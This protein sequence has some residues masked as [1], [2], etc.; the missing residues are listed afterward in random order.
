MNCDT[1]FA[2]YS[3]EPSPVLMFYSISIPK[4]YEKLERAGEN[5]QTPLN[6]AQTALLNHA[7]EFKSQDGCPVVRYY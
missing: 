6:S 3:F 7:V 1:H 5:R 4:L 2:P